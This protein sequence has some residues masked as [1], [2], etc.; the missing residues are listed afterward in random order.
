[1][2]TKNIRLGSMLSFNEEQ[3]QDIIKMIEQLNSCHKTGQFLSNLIRIA[4]DNPEI[5]DRC[6]GKYEYGTAIKQVE[7]LGIS[8]NRKQ[9]MLG[10]TKEV[11]ALKKKVDEIYLMTMKMYMLAQMGKHIGLKEKSDNLLC[12]DFILEKQVKELQTLLGVTFS[13]SVFIANKSNTAHQIADESLEYIINT[14]SGIVDELKNMISTPVQVIQ[15]V[16]QNVVIPSNNESYENND[17]PVIVNDTKMT[18]DKPLANNTDIHDEEDEF[19]EF[20]VDDEFGK[21]T[22]RKSVV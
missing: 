20:G 21:D 17:T 7:S 4:V 16:Q 2:G 15:P 8:Q 12:A 1:M 9:F 3:E 5:I 19:I 10:V 14:Y 18:E 22:D 13:D 11:E 6:N